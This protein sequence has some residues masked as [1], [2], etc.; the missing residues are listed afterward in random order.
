MTLNELN[1]KIPSPNSSLLSGLPLGG[2]KHGFG[3]RVWVLY[4]AHSGFG[5]LAGLYLG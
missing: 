1:K 2:A 5:L 4:V 3:L